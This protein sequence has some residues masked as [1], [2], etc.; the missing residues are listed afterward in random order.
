MAN[1]E[2]NFFGLQKPYDEIS[3]QDNFWDIIEYAED[4]VDLLYWPDEIKSL[5]PPTKWVI[6]DKTFR[7]VS[8]KSTHISF[9]EFTDCRFENCL[10][11]GSTISNCRFNNCDFISCNFFRAQIQNC[12]IDPSSFDHCIDA[13]KHPNIGYSLY[14]ELLHNSRQQVQ[15]DFTR[16]AQYNFARWQRYFL[17]SQIDASK[18]NSL[19][20]F[21]RRMSLIPAWLFEKTTGSGV[22]LINLAIT[23]FLVLMALTTFNYYFRASFGLMLG[24]VPVSSFSEAFY[25]STI[26]V[27]SL[28][29]GDI[30]PT[31]DIGRIVIAF[32]A[33]L[34]F[35]TFATLV[36]MAFRR[37]S[38]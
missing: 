27:T 3:Y 17:R 28:G 31:K 30:T 20:K 18:D 34:G 29:F 38:N 13:S 10:F 11:I 7:N 32:E 6:P 2:D 14:Q 1:T 25:F 5:K 12:F 16:N 33:I 37:I 9:I 21:F 36:S 15:P 22:R 35:L 24:K 26:V 4:V 19:K 8:F 23:S